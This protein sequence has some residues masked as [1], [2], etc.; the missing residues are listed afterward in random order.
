MG[1]DGNDEDMGEPLQ[2]PPDFDGPIRSRRMTD[3]LFTILLWF[4]WISM[5]GLGIYGMQ[6]GEFLN[7]SCPSCT[8][9]ELLICTDTH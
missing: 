7:H 9:L 6:N 4:M 3:V 2:A 1:K 5:T 8:L